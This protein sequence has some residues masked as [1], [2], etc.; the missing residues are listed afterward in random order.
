MHNSGFSIGSANWTIQTDYEKV[1]YLSATSSRTSHTKAVDWEKLKGADVLVLTSVSVAPERN[2]EESVHMLCVTVV[3]TLKR[4]GNVLIPIA[5]TGVLYDLLE[6]LAANLDQSTVSVDTPIYFLSPV[7]ESAL[8][9]ANIYAEWL[10]EKKQNRVYVP[11]EPFPHSIMLKSGR[12]KSFTT[13]HSNFSR[14]FRTPC[15]VFTGH[16]SLRFGDAVHFMELW[17]GDQKNAVLLTDPDYSMMEVLAPFQPLAMRAYNFPIDTRLDF[18]QI[19]ATIMRE[20]APKRVLL[21]E[22]LTKPPATA[23]TR[24]DF[25]VQ[26]SNQTPFRVGDTLSVASSA[27]RKRVRLDPEIAKGMDVS[28]RGALAEAGMCSLRGLL[29]AYDNILELKSDSVD[30]ENDRSPAVRSRLGG[31][32]VGAALIEALAKIGVRAEPVPAADQSVAL[33]RVPDWSAIVAILDEG[34]RSKITCESKANRRRLADV[35]STC[36]T[37][38]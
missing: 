23:P 22:Q 9:Y 7:A 31:Q 32:L 26:H 27:S 8:A 33:V 1:A 28:A 38:L 11:E 12:L 18:G 14:E 2:P 25:V 10:S 20:L 34:K 21:P 16:P 13:M 17:G 5:P 35:I 36:L 6:C 15:V 19:N 29:S 4:G 3:E 24:T 37:P 30:K